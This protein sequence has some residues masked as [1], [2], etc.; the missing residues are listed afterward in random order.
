MEKEE[1]N[2]KGD[3]QEDKWVYYYEDGKI[4]K[5]TYYKDGRCVETCEGDK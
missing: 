1:G 3:K 5:E 2:Y 4:E